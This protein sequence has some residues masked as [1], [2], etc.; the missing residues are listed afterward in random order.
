M[1]LQERVHPSCLLLL[2]PD[3]S[4]EPGGGTWRR[5]PRA[6]R[7]GAEGYAGG[8]VRVGSGHPWAPRRRVSGTDRA[9][10]GLAGCELGQL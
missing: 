1:R 9:A 6:V 3:L 7:P 10:A 2:C 4:G 5:G 8:T